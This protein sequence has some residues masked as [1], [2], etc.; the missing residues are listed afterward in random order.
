MKALRNLALSVFT[1]LRRQGAAAYFDWWGRNPDV[2]LRRGSLA[3]HFL[4]VEARTPELA[5]TARQA[6]EVRAG[7]TVLPF[8]ICGVEGFTRFAVQRS[9]SGA[10]QRYTREVVL[11]SPLPYA[12]FPG[13]GT[14]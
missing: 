3:D 2:G 11:G 13:K 14:D 12:P 9:R 10:I 7:I 6:F 1:V 8:F 5:E 4:V